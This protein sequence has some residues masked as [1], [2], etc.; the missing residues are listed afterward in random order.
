SVPYY[1]DLGEFLDLPAAS[2]R[3]SSLPV[4]F[5]TAGQL[6][7]RKGIDV[8][9]AACE[10]LPD[11]GWSLTIAGDGPL[12]GK[13]KARSRR[14]WP[15]DKVRFLGEVPFKDR[16]AAFSAHDVFVFPSRWDGWGMAPVEA[17]AAGMP[18]ISTD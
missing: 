5:F 7:A 11:T 4:R 1:V 2:A 10:R 16:A 8:L 15:A 3:K 12:Y 13:L 17:M 14:H 18:V 6:I 9:L